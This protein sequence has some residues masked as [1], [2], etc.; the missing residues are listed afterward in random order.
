VN[1]EADAIL[2]LSV[3]SGRNPEQLIGQHVIAAPMVR[4]L[5]LEAIPTAY[6]LVESGGTTGT[7]FMTYS[8]PLP[9]Y[10]PEI[11]VAH[12][13]AAE[14]LGFGL[15]YLEAG[16]G[17]LQSVPDELVRAVSQAVDIP[18]IVGGGLRTREDARGKILAGAAGVVIG[19][20]FERQNN[21][22]AIGLFAECIHA[23]LASQV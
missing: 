6:L 14:L 1:G 10:K 17:A 4:R 8:K 2:F 22:E 18:V 20:H 21:L 19:N 5:G 9:R 12:A 3:L 15:L 13:M 7:E 23:P 16:S 11:A